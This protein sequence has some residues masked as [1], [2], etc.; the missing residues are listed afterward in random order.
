MDLKE[1]HYAIYLKAKERALSQNCD[2]SRELLQ[3]QN[4]QD[5]VA[6]R[7]FTP[8]TEEELK[9]AILSKDIILVGDYHTFDQSNKN[10]LR[11]FT[12]LL[13]E[14][15]NCTIAVEFIH[16]ENQNIVDAFVMGHLTEIEFLEQI[17]YQESWH[18]PWP[19]YKKF[20]ELA[21]INNI[22]IIALNSVG[23]LRERD[24]FA[25]ELIRKIADEK[26]FVFI[27][28]LHIIEDKLPRAIRKELPEKEVLVIHQNLD[29]VYWKLQK[30]DYIVRF[31]ENEFSIQNSPPWIKYE[32]LNYW[33]DYL[34]EDPDFDIHEYILNQG[35]FPFNSQIYEKF[36]ECCHKIIEAFDFNI[37]KKEANNFNL[38]DHQSLDYLLSQISLEK[39]KTIADF[40]QNQIIAGELFNFIDKNIY[41]CS[42][43]SFN[44]LIM[45]VGNHLFEIMRKKNNGKLNLN[46]K[47][48][49]FA[50]FTFKRIFSYF[51]TKVFNPF[52]KCDRYQDIKDLDLKIVI[53]SET[54]N[55]IDFILDKCD[56]NSLNQKARVLGSY[57]GE[58][59]YEAIYINN[60]RRYWFLMETIFETE[61]SLDIL[62]F[63]TRSVFQEGLY[64]DETKRKF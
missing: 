63:I 64:E 61:F 39:N 7:S 51:V 16:H 9:E 47:S 36:Q 55:E 58:I 53:D 29:H 42:T 41:Y 21:K 18:F 33:V 44:R 26:V 6:K 25:S 56:I 57:I 40:Y 32:S 45:L 22:K 30:G 48:N 19:H 13:E 20:F 8:S 28:E 50:Y 11:I 3:Y 62:F 27:G 10:F 15:T 4:D 38:Y 1:L 35:A 14:K 23:T 46:C 49:L 60:D 54:T 43:Y 34:D 12:K 31:N 24:K 52:R 17:N 37:T 2:S 5:A 59:M